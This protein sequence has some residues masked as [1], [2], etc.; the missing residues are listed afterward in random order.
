V[1]EDPAATEILLGVL[2]VAAAHGA[3]V[4]VEGVETEE[5]LAL[6]ERHGFRFLQGFLLSRPVAA[7]AFETALRG[8]IVPERS[9]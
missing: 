8:G 3:D 9:R 5:Q 6:L 4:T 2:R 1:P 7:A